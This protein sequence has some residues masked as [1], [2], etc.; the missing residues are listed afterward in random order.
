MN[1]E[2][3]KNLKKKMRVASLLVSIKIINVNRT[4]LTNIKQ[5]SDILKRLSNLYC[6]Q[7]INISYKDKHTES[8]GIETGT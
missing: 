8:K 6:F 4:N 5:S 1:E 3:D 2:I 7:K